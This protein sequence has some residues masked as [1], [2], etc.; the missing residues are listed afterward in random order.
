MIGKRAAG[1]RVSGGRSVGDICT[2]IKVG[3]GHDISGGERPVGAGGDRLAGGGDGRKCACT[4]LNITDCGVERHITGICDSISVSDRITFA[5][6]AIGRCELRKCCRRVWR[7]ESNCLHRIHISDGATFGHTAHCGGVT[8]RI[9]CIQV[10]LLD[11]IGRRESRR[12]G[13][14]EIIDFQRIHRRQRADTAMR[15]RNRDVIHGD[16]TRIGDDIRISDRLTDCDIGVVGCCLGQRHT[17]I[18]RRSRN[19]QRT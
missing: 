7:D 9:V 6:I 17:I 5:D 8:N 1:G 14:G 11:D 15:V 13:R 3:L 10:A 18:G 4:G 16:V 2:R 12:L 19:G